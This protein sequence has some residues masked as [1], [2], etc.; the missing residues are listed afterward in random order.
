[1]ECV[2]ANLIWLCT[3][4]HTLKQTIVIITNQFQVEKLLLQS[5]LT[6]KICLG[7]I[8]IKESIKTLI[9]PPIVFFSQSIFQWS[10]CDKYL[11]LFLLHTGVSY[12]LP[13]CKHP[14]LLH[15]YQIPFSC[16]LCYCN[17]VPYAKTN[18]FHL[19]VS[20]W[21]YLLPVQEELTYFL[22]IYSSSDTVSWEHVG[23]CIWNCPI[24]LSW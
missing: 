13:S 21:Q 15:S 5:R 12:I 19:T 9:L 22:R 20:D 7:D 1:M 16:G 8:K 24:A 17:Y 6:F 14:L 18:F 10:R 11:F 3:L 2:E 23:T 4:I